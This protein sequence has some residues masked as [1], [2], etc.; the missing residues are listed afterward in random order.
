MFWSRFVARTPRQFRAAMLLL[1]VIL[2]WG[3]NWPVMKIG[4]R[5]MPPLWFASVR[6]LFGSAT[7]FALLG[8]RTRLPPKADVPVFASGTVF[9]LFIFLALTHLALT[10]E[11]A[12]RSAILAYTT[13]LWVAP[14]AVVWL[15]ER[16][17]KA[18]VIALA[19]GMAG[20]CVL[21]NPLTFNWKQTDL[22]Q[23]NGLLV[24][25]A[26]AW[27]VAIVHMRGHRWVSTPLTLLPWQML[28]AGLA[29][30][31]VAAVVHS[32]A[33]AVNW[34]TRLWLVI[35]YN[36]PIA[37]AFCFWAFA[38]VARALPAN[39]TALGSLGVPVVGLLVS[40]VIL[41]EPLS[42]EKIVGLALILMAVSGLVFSHTRR[43]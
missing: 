19:F 39:T 36:G 9:Q 8:L 20:L 18:R 30:A 24:V 42:I 22:V 1:L 2:L 5:D 4:L 7:L 32:E 15:G 6:L 3:A 40:A 41:H 16:M 43:T 35:I 26:M 11:G 28:L 27:A 21:F 13:P 17:S 37:S 14:M 38:T 25:A 12:G 33:P 34:T 31:A 23:A 10:A 29:L